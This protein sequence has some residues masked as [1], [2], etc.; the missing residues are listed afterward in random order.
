MSP[1]YC[2][3]GKEENSLF[4]REPRLYTR[5]CPSAGP[6]VR[7]S[8][9][10]LSR[11]AETSQRTT[12]FVSTNLF[13]PFDVTY[14]CFFLPHHPPELMLQPS[15]PPALLQSPRVTKYT[16]EITRFGLALF[17]L[18]I[19]YFWLLWGIEDSQWGHKWVICHPRRVIRKIN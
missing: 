14:L 11:R 12:Y 7:P 9:M 19:W 13:N 2:H 15:T 10:L 4:S 8:V 16:I 3:I 17:S 1:S 6:S 5:V 18:L